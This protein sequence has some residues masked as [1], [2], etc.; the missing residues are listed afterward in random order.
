MQIHANNDKTCIRHHQ[1]LTG[2]VLTQ[3]CPVSLPA[4]RAHTHKEW[5][6]W[7]IQQNIQPGRYPPQRATTYATVSCSPVPPVA[8]LPL[9]ETVFS[10]EWSNVSSSRFAS[11]LL[12]ERCSCSLRRLCRLYTTCRTVST[13]GVPLTEQVPF[14]CDNSI[15]HYQ[16]SQSCLYYWK[17]TNIPVVLTNFRSSHKSPSPRLFCQ[18]CMH[19]K[20]QHYWQNTELH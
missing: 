14:H 20:H 5:S 11:A 7:S 2:L 10:P 3:M 16:Q 1:N 18:H 17:S 6:D 4:T 8:G 19:T 12:V 15:Q 13:T 9:S